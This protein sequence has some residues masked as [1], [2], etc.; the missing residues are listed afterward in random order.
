M[1]EITPER[2]MGERSDRRK[3]DEQNKAAPRLNPE[4]SGIRTGN[5][6]LDPDHDSKTDGGQGREE[7]TRHRPDD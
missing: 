6:Q 3:A 2:V 4:K 5:P 1:S 7:K